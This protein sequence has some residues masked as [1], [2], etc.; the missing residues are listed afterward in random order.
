LLSNALKFTYKGY[1]KVRIE[2]TNHSNMN[3]SLL[4]GDKDSNVNVI[5]VENVDRN[6]CTVKFTI[7]DT[8]IGIREED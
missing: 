3:D 6:S 4:E 7:E 1:I 8:G 2:R 5:G